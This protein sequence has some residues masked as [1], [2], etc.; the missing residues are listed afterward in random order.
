MKLR[1]GQS[2]KTKLSSTLK[3]WLPLL[4][5]P[6]SQLHNELTTLVEH[7]PFCR[8]EMSNEKLFD[9]ESEEEWD[10]D[11]GFLKSSNHTAIEALHTAKES[12]FDHL[13]A[14]LESR[15]FPTPRSKQ[16]ATLIIHAINDEGFFEGDIDQIAQQ[17]HVSSGEVESVRQ[18]FRAL[19]PSGVGAKDIIESYDFQLD[20]C[21]CDQ[22]VDALARVIIHHLDKAVHY[23]HYER[24]SEAMNLIKRL[25]NPPAIHFLED[26]EAVIPDVY[27][28]TIDE[29]LVVTLNDHYYPTIH[30]ES[31]EG[32]EKESFVKPKIKEAKDLIDALMMRKQTLYKLAL[33]I[34]EYQYDFFVGGDIKPMRLVDLSEELGRNPS[35]ISRAISGKYIACSRGIIPMKEF[36]S[37]ALD[38]SLSSSTIKDFVRKAV[39]NEPHDDVLSDEKILEM[40]EEAYGIKIVRRTVTKYRK[41]LDIPSSSQRK[42]LYAFGCAS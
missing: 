15:F 11:E 3:S 9:E 2:A 25:V 19:T 26:D 27:I 24:F 10:D 39:K 18:R 31:V 20:D 37:T 6:L 8:L 23:S 33:M 13:F 7:N 34:V 1:T 41:E 16:I 4:Q 30:I 22:D 35:T 17:C 5:C 28:Q 38:E 42:K 21:E 14:Q 40:I 12:L 32:F 29:E 36:F